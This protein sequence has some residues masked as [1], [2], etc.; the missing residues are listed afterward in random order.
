MTILDILLKAA[1]EPAAA[2]K[3][4][5]DAIKQRFPDSAPEVDAIEQAL[6]TTL[7]P[8]A[9]AALGTT[10]LGELHNIASGKIDSHFHPSD[11]G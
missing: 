9:L 4:L 2:L 6:A 11:A 3:G 7:D 10:V 5:L 1:G 8:A